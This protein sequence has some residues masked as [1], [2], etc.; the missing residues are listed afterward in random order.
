MNILSKFKAKLAIGTA[1]LVMAVMPSGMVPAGQLAVAYAAGSVNLQVENPGLLP[2][3]PFYFIKS[4]KRSTQRALTINIV[5]KIDLELDILNQKAAEVQRLY[6]IMPD[7]SSVLFDALN[8]YQVNINNLTT[9]VKKLSDVEKD[10]AF[11]RLIDKLVSHSVN[12]LKLFDEI[13]IAA[14]IRLKEKLNGLQSGISGMVADVIMIEG[15]DKFKIQYFG[16]LGN[17]SNDAIKELRAVEIL[18]YFEEKLPVNSFERQL[19]AR[20]KEEIILS[21]EAILGIVDGAEASLPASLEGLSG[22]AWRR[23]KMLDEAREYVKSSVLKNNLTLV[24]QLI[25][26]LAGQLR[27]I[28]KPEAERLANEAKDQSNSLKDKNLILKSAF[29]DVAILKA[30]FNLKQAQE[31]M[32]NGQYV[33]SFGQASAAT[34][35]LENALSQS[36][37]L[38]N[39]NLN[40][41]IKTMKG[42]YDRLVAVSQENGLNLE[43]SPELFNFLSQAEKALTKLSDGKNKKFDAVVLAVRDAKLLLFKSEWF[44]NDMIGRIE[45]K[46]KAKY[47]SQTLIQKAFTDENKE[48]EIKKEVIKEL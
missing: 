27:T 45:E 35:V 17:L 5:K 46:I 47:N 39:N 40:N 3:N 34:S 8:S 4:F 23:I 7:D 15:V 48:K 13:K 32:A 28:G 9:S 16:I 37:I 42:K 22:D 2:T 33:Y 36:L 25:L 20:F 24:R 26:D 21:A 19:L 18:G 14:D 10:I 38:M 29:L 30:E 41:E 44:L 1:V 12:H 11:D 43:N 31:S 6:E